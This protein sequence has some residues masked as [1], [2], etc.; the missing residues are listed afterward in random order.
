MV[1]T[2]FLIIIFLSSNVYG[3]EL[4]RLPAG[5]RIQFQSET[6]QG[7]SLEEM[8]ILL[9][10]DVDLEFFE[11]SFP[12]QKQQ[13]LLLEKWL[14]TKEK[15]LKSKDVQIDLLTKD[16]ERITKKWEEENLLRH[17]CEQKPAFGSW[18]AWSS[19]GLFAITTLILGVLLIDED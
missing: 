9:K 6:Y 19:A 15:R 7:Y 4:Y 14:D 8:K 13:I 3:R 17:K 1:K 2:I 16:R 10:M 5:K 11:E 12:A 18:I